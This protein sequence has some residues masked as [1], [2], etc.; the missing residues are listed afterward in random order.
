MLLIPSEKGVQR[1]VKYV[2]WWNQGPSMMWSL[3]H[4]DI[5]LL[6]QKEKLTKRLF[7]GFET[8][9]ESTGKLTEKVSLT[10]IS[11]SSQTNLKPHWDRLRLLKKKGNLTANKIHNILPGFLQTSLWEQQVSLEA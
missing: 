8:T 2:K 5:S 6:F 4:W 11:H 9:I 1:K 3:S 7:K 10:Y